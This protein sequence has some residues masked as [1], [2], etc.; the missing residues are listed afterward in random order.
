VVATMASTAMTE[1]M[2][3]NGVLVVVFCRG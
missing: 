2:L 1:E 3:I